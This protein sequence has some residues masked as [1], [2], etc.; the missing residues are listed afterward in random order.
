MSEAGYYRDAAQKACEDLDMKLVSF[1][2]G[3]QKYEAIRQWL[4]DIGQ[5]WS[6]KFRIY[7]N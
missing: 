2:N 4:R 6:R 1:E 3:S 7:L 5:F